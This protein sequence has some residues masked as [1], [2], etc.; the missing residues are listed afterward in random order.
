MSNESNLLY[1][2]VAHVCR[3]QRCYKRAYSLWNRFCNLFFFMKCAIARR[4]YINKKVPK[5]NIATGISYDAL[6]Y[7]LR[8]KSRKG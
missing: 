2:Q 3:P 8:M 6:I 7:T 5:G 1:K 4:I